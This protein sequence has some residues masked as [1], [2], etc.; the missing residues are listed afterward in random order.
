M[1]SLTTSIPSE[2]IHEVGELDHPGGVLSSREHS[3][4]VRELELGAAATSHLAEADRYRVVA[5]HQQRCNRAR[6][7]LW[8]LEDQ[9]LA[10]YN[11]TAARHTRGERTTSRNWN[12]RIVKVLGEATNRGP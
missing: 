8:E 7:R 12:E 4:E 10:V 6:G 9:L 1:P 3:A 5:R 11:I 2:S